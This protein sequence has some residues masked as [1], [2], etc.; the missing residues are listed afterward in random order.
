MT[1]RAAKHRLNKENPENEV[2]QSSNENI[3]N[4]EYCQ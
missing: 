4:N 3:D 1:Y 2:V